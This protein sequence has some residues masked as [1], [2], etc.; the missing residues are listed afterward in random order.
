MTLRLTCKE[1]GEIVTP[2]LFSTFYLSPFL[3][4]VA[5]SQRFQ[6]HLKILT[7]ERQKGPDRSIFWNKSTYELLIKT[8]LQT[9][10]WNSFMYDILGKIPP[11]TPLP[12]S[13]DLALLPN[14]RILK[15][16]DKW[17]IA[18]KAQSTTKIQP[19]Y[20]EISA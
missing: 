14:L 18:K 6:V 7:L 20:C 16:G 10:S 13:L 3:H 2:Q 15:A 17:I 11:N 9:Y 1:L 12:F 5:N 4:T 8:L 19:G